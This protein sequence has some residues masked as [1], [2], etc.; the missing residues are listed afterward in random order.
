MLQLIVESG[1]FVWD[2]YPDRPATTPRGGGGGGDWVAARAALGLATKRQVPILI[3]RG[4]ALRISRRRAC[5]M[6]PDRTSDGERGRVGEGVGG[7]V[8]PVAVDCTFSILDLFLPCP[9]LLC[10]EEGLQVWEVRGHITLAIG[11]F[12]PFQACREVP[13]RAG[14]SLSS[15]QRSGGC[16]CQLGYW[17]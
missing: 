9:R 14:R 1:N 4:A 13:D 15:R 10:G 16:G 3:R 12:P 6:E 2:Q 17:H 11:P 5:C 8:F 7:V